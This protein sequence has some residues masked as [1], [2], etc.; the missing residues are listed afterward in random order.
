VIRIRREGLKG[1]DL[2]EI[3]R[4]LAERAT[5]ELEA[6]TVITVDA[7]GARIRRLPIRFF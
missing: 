1:S 4:T 3:L 6:G 2:A 5:M 7:I